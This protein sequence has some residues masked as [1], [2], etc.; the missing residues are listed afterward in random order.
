ML[1]KS[2]DFPAS[3]IGKFQCPLH[4]TGEIICRK[5]FAEPLIL[6]SGPRI[7]IKKRKTPFALLC[8]ERDSA[9]RRG[10]WNGRGMEERRG[11]GGGGWYGLQGREDRFWHTMCWSGGSARRGAQV[12]SYDTFWVEESHCE[13]RIR[14]RRNILPR[15]Q[16]RA[17]INLP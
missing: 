10:K 12:L 14:V 15:S 3:N 13:W 11:G 7:L 6:L 9:E 8:T 16:S 5:K 4:R 17:A 1:S 2:D